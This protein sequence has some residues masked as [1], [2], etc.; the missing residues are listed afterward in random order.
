MW[1]VPFFFHLV[2]A[3]VAVLITNNTTSSTDHPALPNYHETSRLYLIR[4]SKTPYTHKRD[5]GPTY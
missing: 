3:Q 4:I 1:G 5:D 2:P